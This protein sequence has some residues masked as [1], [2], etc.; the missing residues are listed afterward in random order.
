MQVPNGPPVAGTRSIRIDIPRVGQ[1]F[2]FTKVMNVTDEA[3][4][5]KMSV[6]KEK[7]FVLWRSLLQFSVF[8]AGL[9]ILWREWRRSSLP[10]TRILPASRPRSQSSAKFS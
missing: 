5:I 2:T 9:I 8:V 1:P 4:S 6:M 10:A 7:W 3:L